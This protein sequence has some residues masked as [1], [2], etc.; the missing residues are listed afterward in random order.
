MKVKAL[1]NGF[2]GASQRKA[3][4]VFNWPEGLPL[5]RW[6]EKLPDPPKPKA[7]PE[8]KELPKG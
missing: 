8:T 4:E 3:S 5:G 6:V 1:K 2:D 7:K